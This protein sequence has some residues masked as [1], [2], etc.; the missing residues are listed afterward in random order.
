MQND[1]FPIAS[2]LLSLLAVDTYEAWSVIESITEL[3]D[4][5]ASGC[6]DDEEIERIHYEIEYAFAIG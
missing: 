2:A 1:N 3:A 6:I 4:S 5:L